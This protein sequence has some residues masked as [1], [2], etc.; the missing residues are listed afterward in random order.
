MAEEKLKG[1][2]CRHSY[3]LFIPLTEM[4]RTISMLRSAKFALSDIRDNIH[5]VLYS[6]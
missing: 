2:M 3:W 4:K 5:I 1:E 6:G